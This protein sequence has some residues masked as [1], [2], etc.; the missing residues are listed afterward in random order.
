MIRVCHV[1]TLTSIGG[2]EVFLKNLFVYLRENPPRLDEVR[3]FLLTTSSDLVLVNQI[4][5]YVEWFQPLGKFRYDPKKILRMTKYYQQQ[6]IDIIHSY[7]AYA[8][9]WAFLSRNL[10]SRKPAFVTHEHGTVWD[11]GGVFKF[12]DKLAQ[13]NADVV[14]ANSRAT[15]IMLQ[16]C[17]GVPQNKIRIVHNGVIVPK[18]LTKEEARD[19]L[20][21]PKDVKI[22]GSVG[23]L[24]TPK[25]YWT[26]IDAAKE[27][28]KHKDVFFYLV[29]G[30]PQEAFLRKIVEDYNISDRFIITGPQQNGM[31]WIAAFDLFVSTSIHESFGNVLVEASLLEKPIIAPAVDG[32]VD[33]IKHNQTGILLQPSQPVRKVLLQG[34][35]P[36][37]RKVV[38]GERLVPPKSLDPELLADIII[39]L[40]SDSER[41][42][43][44]A[45]NAR[46][47]ATECFNMDLYIT[48]TY[49]IYSEL[50]ES[51]KES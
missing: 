10:I 18:F 33:I 26:F 27:V 40:L 44:L 3:H 17:Y 4:K 22:V 6:Q 42:R 37:P 50:K 19:R 30:G 34:A 13:R 38:I 39:T 12:S 25:D 23:R 51:I 7:N 36:Y 47:R 16:K 49:Q 14:I 21:L 32:I 11:A 45:R 46:E 1:S 9:T 41:A 31:T 24:N 15:S 35:S 5:V 29:G 20:G 28:L 8:N 2:V 48:K 43:F